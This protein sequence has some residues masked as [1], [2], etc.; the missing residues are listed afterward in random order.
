MLA[1][2]LVA[3]ITGLG[4][5]LN[6]SLHSILT[7]GKGQSGLPTL[8][9]IGTNPIVEFF[10]KNLYGDNKVTDIFFGNAGQAS[11]NTFQL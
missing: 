10:T 7:T 2:L 4:M 9:K 5:Y 11:M 8:Q 3:A 6:L 1:V